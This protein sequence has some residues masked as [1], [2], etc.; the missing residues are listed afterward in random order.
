MPLEPLLF[1]ALLVLAAFALLYARFRGRRGD[2]AASP[3]RSEVRDRI[4]GPSAGA[5]PVRGR[6]PGPRADRSRGSRPAPAASAG[7][8]PVV[9]ARLGTL[10][11]VRRGIVLMTLLGPCRALEAAPPNP[12][13]PE[14]GT[15]HEGDR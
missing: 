4:P 14:R 2:E 9:H 6:P 3:D 12:R 7:T 13:S 10:G 8:R 5:A 15:R 11:D 1:P